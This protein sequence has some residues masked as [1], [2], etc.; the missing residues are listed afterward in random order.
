MRLFGPIVHVIPYST[1]TQAV[2]FA[3]GVPYALTAG[4]FAQSSEDVEFFARRL[5]AGNLYINRPITAARV[6]V[7]PFGGIQT[8]RNRPE[9]RW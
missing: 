5:D 3:N 4:I 1:P 9:S 7:E 6:G 2:Q 8:L